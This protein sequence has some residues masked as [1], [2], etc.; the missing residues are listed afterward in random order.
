MYVSVRKAS[1]KFNRKKK[2]IAKGLMSTY[3]E[4]QRPVKIC[5][6]WQSSEYNLGFKYARVLNMQ[7][8]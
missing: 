6:S 7:E 4:I 2:Y 3:C 5:M 8:I 1:S